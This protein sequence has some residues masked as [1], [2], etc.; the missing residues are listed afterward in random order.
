MCI[1]DSPGASHPPDHSP[2]TRNPQASAATPDN[3][4]SRHRSGTR[5]GPRPSTSGTAR[6]HEEHPPAQATPVKWIGQIA[7]IAK[8]TRYIA[9]F[10]LRQVQ[11]SACLLY[12]SDAADDLT[13][14]DL[15]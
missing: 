4:D 7:L 15:G 8:V 6:Q 3:R 10:R 9:R 14:V 12:T 1:R 2:D 13:R 11:D 5:L